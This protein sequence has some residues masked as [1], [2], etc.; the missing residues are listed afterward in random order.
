M[1]SRIAPLV[2][3]LTRPATRPTAVAAVRSMVTIQEAMTADDARK[4]SC[5]SSIDYSIDEDATVLDAV[6]KF[7][8]FNIGCLV[9]T[10]ADGTFLLYGHMGK[11][12]R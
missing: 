9:T 11:H 2:R 6:Q 4:I 3:N 12:K 8:A 1:F 10:D 5:Y 7:A